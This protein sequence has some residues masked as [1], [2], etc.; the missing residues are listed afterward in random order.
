VKAVQ[1]RKDKYFSKTD[2][3]TIGYPYVKNKK[4]V[5]YAIYKN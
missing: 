4:D 3:G 2:T 1:W 5:H